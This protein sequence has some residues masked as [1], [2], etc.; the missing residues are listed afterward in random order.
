[1]G[2]GA[3]YRL[4]PRRSKRDWHGGTCSGVGPMRDFESGLTADRLRELLRYSPS[5][6]EFHWRVTNSIRKPAGSLA[7]DRKESGYVLI[8]IDGNRYRAHRLAWL[9]MTGCWPYDQVDHKDNDRS[10]NKWENLRLATNQQNQANSR[11]SKN[12]TSGVKGVYWNRQ[13]QKW[14]AKLCLGSRQI[15]GGFF[16]EIEHAAAAYLGLARAHHGEFA[17]AA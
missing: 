1:M 3:L 16:D 6:G 12:N 8:G 14:H 13:R 2:E 11:T 5:T 10:N 9:Y 7:G 17:R 4:E 15:H